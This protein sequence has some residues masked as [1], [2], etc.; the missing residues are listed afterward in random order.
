MIYLSTTGNGSCLASADTTN[1][2]FTATPY[3]TITSNDSA[4]ASNPV[5]LNVATT[6]GSGIWSSSGTGTFAPS[7]TIASPVYNPS[8]ADDA[9][10][11]VTMIY[12]TTNNGGCR[13]K[14]DT[15]NITLIPSPTA[16]YSSVSACPTFPV[17]FTDAS[18]ASTGSVVSWTWN[19]GDGSPTNTT[20]NPSHSYPVGGPYNVS[21]IVTSTNGCVDT[22]TQVV[23]VYY[24]PDA[25]F[26]ANGICLHDGT[27]FQDSSSVVNSTIAGWSW[28]FGDASTGSTTQNPVHNYPGAGSY[29]T[30]LIVQSAQGCIDTVTHVVG[31][32][33][34]P[35]ADF[36]ADD[37]TANQNQVVNFSDQSSGAVSWLWNFGDGSSDSTSTLQNP[38]HVWTEGGFY[39]VCLY[40]TDTN[41]CTDTVCKT[42]IISM[43]PSVPS[44]F[45]PNGDGVNDILYVYGG[46]FKELHFKIFNNWGEV[47]FES[48][49]QS[50]GWDGKR[51]GIDQPIGVYVYVVTG[52][53][54]DGQDH[55]I[56]GDVTLL[57]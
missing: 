27:L 32:L 30:S 7:D 39:D 36:T 37:F 56:S 15:I 14:A 20:Q 47:I 34:G 8:P 2:I 1:I 5:L 6:T 4:C 24:K 12:T 44:G 3:A 55:K 26:E 52:V 19:F 35:A 42:E 29:T 40:V 13:A 57:R 9:A 33:P 18:T 46:P 48:T 49:E 22:L 50:V 51:N 16:A 53:T 21:L 31:V 25:E 11:N 45:S 41:G 38:T 43:P 54:E 28:D 17:N 10:G 23:D